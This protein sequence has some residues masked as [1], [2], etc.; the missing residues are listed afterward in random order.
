MV[1]IHNAAWIGTRAPSL[2]AKIFGAL[3]AAGWIGVQLFFVLS[4]L[5]ITSI[6]LE[7]RARTDFLRNFYLRRALRIFPLYYATL[8]ATVVGAVVFGES[9]EWATAVI[10]NQWAYWLYLSNWT[11]PF[12]QSVKVLSHV[13]SLAV[14]EQFYLAWPILVWWLGPRGLALLSLTMVVGGPP[15]RY[16]LHLAN[17]PA[18]ALYSFTISRWDALAAGALLATALNDR[19]FRDL[20][21]RH[22]FTGGVVIGSLLMILAVRQRGFHE[23]ELPIQVAGQ[24]LIALLSCLALAWA[25]RLDSKENRFSFAVLGHGFLPHLG[26]YSYGIYLLHYPIHRG[27]QPILQAWINGGG[28]G[29]YLGRVIGYCLLVLG[30]AYT[31]AR[32]SWVMVEQPFLMLKDRWAPKPLRSADES[33]SSRTS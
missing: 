19:S 26:R 16:A 12:G 18:A 24:T 14:E 25:L 1:V 5:L 9:S 31:A 2:P 15:L 29:S 27:L 30:L 7:T 28:A 32:L 21:Y 3:A 6:L 8:S 33:P 10:N 23:T 20:L 22:M 4:G 13:W 17:L 11:E